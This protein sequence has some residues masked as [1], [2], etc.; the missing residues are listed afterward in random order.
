MLKPRYCCCISA[1]W[2][3][4]DQEIIIDILV[5]GLCFLGLFLFLQESQRLI[6]KRMLC[7]GFCTVFRDNYLKV[8]IVTD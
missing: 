7:L 6:L 8:Y 5:A 4:T 3:N 2:L 1:C